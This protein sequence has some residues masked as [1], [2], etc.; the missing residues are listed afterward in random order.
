VDT[1]YKISFSDSAVTGKLDISILPNQ[2]DESTSLIL[3]GYGS[4]QYG[5]HLWENMVHLMEH[6]CSWSKEPLHPTEGQLWYNAAN[7]SLNLRTPDA[8][9]ILKWVNIIPNFGFDASASSLSNDSIPTLATIKNILKDYVSSTGD[10][11]ITGNLTLNDAIGN[12]TQNGAIYEPNVT[13]NTNR[14]F[15]ASRFYVDNK[16]TKYVTDQL[17]L[18]KPATSSGVTAKSVI[19]VMGNAD[20]KANP[21]LDRDST[22]STKRTM[23]QP[24]ILRS[25]LYTDTSVSE[26]EAV[27]KKFITSIL[28]GSASVLNSA[29]V[30]NF[31][32][33]AITTAVNPTSLVAKAGDT[34]TGDLLL[35]ATT[36]TTLDSAAATKKYVDDQLGK[37]S[38]APLSDTVKASNTKLPDGTIMIYGHGTGAIVQTET[39][40]GNANT[41]STTWFNAVVTFPLTVAFTNTHYS[42]TVTEDI[43]ASGSTAAPYPKSRT[44]VGTT[45]TNKT[46]QTSWPLSFSVYG[47][48]TTSFKICV[49]VPNGID[50]DYVA[51]TLSYNFIAIGR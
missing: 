3:H 5:E 1:T 13:T 37:L 19:E 45:K 48:T 15:A 8:A 44:F 49:F 10:Y 30:V 41:N 50:L 36:P 35:P 34:M 47:K 43:P 18:F 27:S 20:A 23:S 2:T 9:G 25:M 16:V 46:N 28:A 42:V 29:N 11:I 4:L 14:F 51:K 24:L 38:P 32:N 21:Y 26:N 33:Q 40:T 12:Y 39:T 22:D 17:N 6:F 31:L 7:K